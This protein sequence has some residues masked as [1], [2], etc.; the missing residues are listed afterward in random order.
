MSEK[1]ELSIEDVLETL[2]KDFGITPKA[3]APEVG[4]PI[5]DDLAFNTKASSELVPMTKATA[6]AMNTLLRQLLS[7]DARMI[8]DGGKVQQVAS[9]AKADAGPDGKPFFLSGDVQLQASPKGEHKISS[10]GWGGALKFIQDSSSWVRGLSLGVH[11]G[12]DEYVEYAKIGCFDGVNPGLYGNVIGRLLGTADNSDLL[13]HKAESLLSVQSAVHIPDRFEIQSVSVNR[14]TRTGVIID[15]TVGALQ[16]Q[17]LPDGSELEFFGKDGVVIRGIKNGIAEL[18]KGA[19]GVFEIT[20][21]GDANAGIQM[22]HSVSGVQWSL[23]TRGDPHHDATLFSKKY[24]DLIR[25]GAQGVIF[26]GSNPTPF[27]TSTAAQ[28]LRAIHFSE[29]GG[30][31]VPAMA[32]QRDRG[33]CRDGYVEVACAATA[34]G[35]SK[36]AGLMPITA[37]NGRFSWGNTFMMSP[38]N[39]SVGIGQ[40]EVTPGQVWCDF[41][42]VP[43][44]VLLRFT[45]AGTG[46]EEA[47][48]QFL[49]PWMEAAIGKRG[50][51]YARITLGGARVYISHK[52]G[53][54][55]I[56]A[57]A[58]LHAWW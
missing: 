12:Y 28:G 27:I 25:E 54:R 1:F 55:L 15:K 37:G 24:G 35:M 30:A 56:I 23:V 53:Q 36:P 39:Q 31:D 19:K 47:L 16:M 50:Q 10:G 52:E 21:D 5:K 11:D 8:G 42:A 17:A 9:A 20:N 2:K 41:A 22:N 4:V 44:V 46:D 38:P 7:N 33:N 34:D 26:Y 45:G 43:K 14:N 51:C 58:L 13:N 40:I 48:T 6:G 18:A 29:A 32:I 57:G 49:T 3:K